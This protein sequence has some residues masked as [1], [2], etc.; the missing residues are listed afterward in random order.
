VYPPILLLGKGSVNTF[1]RQRMYAQGQTRFNEFHRKPHLNEQA[2]NLIHGTYAAHVTYVAGDSPWNSEAEGLPTYTHPDI[3]N[4]NIK[5]LCFVYTGHYKDMS[6]LYSSQV[7]GCLTMGRFFVSDKRSPQNNYDCSRRSW[8][9]KYGNIPQKMGS[10]PT[11]THR[12]MLSESHLDFDTPCIHQPSIWRQ[13]FP[14]KSRHPSTRLHGI[15]THKVTFWRRD[16]LKFS[17][18]YSAYRTNVGTFNIHGKRC[19]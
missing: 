11:R 8:D 18:L 16:K 6:I 9:L 15:T 14:Q 13:Q 5:V 12:L 1:P 10:T 7:L 3:Y 4:L 17:F 2:V 19:F